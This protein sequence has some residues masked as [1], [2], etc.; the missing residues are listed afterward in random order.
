MCGLN[1]LLLLGFL[2]QGREGPGQARPL[3]VELENSEKSN[4]G[5]S[6]EPNTCG[7][8]NGLGHV[9]ANDIVESNVRVDGKQH[10]ERQVH[11]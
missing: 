4:N 3:D 2:P 10:T 7:S 1:F 6:K 11:W 8:A 9:V 5:G